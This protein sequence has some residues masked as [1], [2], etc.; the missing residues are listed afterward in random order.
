VKPAMEKAN[1][2]LEKGNYASY[3]QKVTEF[4]V[5]LTIERIRKESAIIAGL[6]REGKVK[7]VGG[8]YDIE[9]GMVQFYEEKKDFAP[10]FA[11]LE[12]IMN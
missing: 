12:L 2:V 5:H 4:N 8:L 3:V 10:R 9:T 1:M 6:E 7:I 11:D